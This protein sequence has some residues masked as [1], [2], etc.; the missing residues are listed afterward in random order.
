MEETLKEDF[1]AYLNDTPLGV[2]DGQITEFTPLQSGQESAVYRFALN[3]SGEGFSATQHLILKH[4]TNTPTNIDRVQKERHALFH[5]RSR[6]FPVPGVVL[7]EPFP[8]M[9]NGPFVVMEFVEGATLHEALLSADDHEREVLLTQAMQTL[10]R[11]HQVEVSVL[12]GRINPLTSFALVN[13]DVQALRKLIAQDARLTALE[14]LTDWLHARRKDAPC[15]SP[16]ITHRDFV[17]SNLIVSA[18]AGLVVV[19]WG[20]QIGD[21]RADVAWTLNAIAR[22]LGEDARDIARAA[23]QQASED[24][25]E[26]LDFFELMAELRWVLETVLAFRAEE[27][28][29]DSAARQQMALEPIQQ[30]LTIL[31]DRTGLTLPDADDLLF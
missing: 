8:Q 7:A 10:A 14:P 22:L 17:P 27:A 26:H 1:Q 19:D 2:N 23:Y 13:R 16:V 24:P 20:W 5:L 4:F 25:L 15:E 21:P 29:L 12:V 28:T 30:A 3:Q 18:D 31:S 6:G 11:L 9:L